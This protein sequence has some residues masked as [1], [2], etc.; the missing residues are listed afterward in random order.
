[1]QNSSARRIAMRVEQ[2]DLFTPSR[3]EPAS[4]P[5][6]QGTPTLNGFYYEQNTRKFVSYV[7]GRR[8][9]ET[10]GFGMPVE[11]KDKIKRE[12]SI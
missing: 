2:L 5:C 4:A 9:Y 7:M 8:H 11:W 6:V 1:M 12:R 3:Q 10:N